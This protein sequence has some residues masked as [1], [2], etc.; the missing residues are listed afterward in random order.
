[1]DSNTKY[2][3][4]HEWI[5]IDDGIAT[6][7]I[8]KHAAEELGEIVFVELPK[9]NLEVGQMDEIGTIESVKTVSSLFSPL[10]GKIVEVNT[11]LEGTPELIN[12]ASD[13]D[14][15]IFKMKI[16]DMVEANDLMTEE[17]YQTFLETL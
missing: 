2:T 14:G 5:K 11:E 12:D 4:E 10:T 9:I 1:M 17:E 7:G 8:S 13:D 6:V 3:E 16:D 15:W